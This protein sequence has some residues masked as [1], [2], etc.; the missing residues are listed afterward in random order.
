MK[1]II[2]IL[3]AALINFSGYSKPKKKEIFEHE[4][5][6]LVPL[7]LNTDHSDFGPAI[8]G[9]S[10]YFSS[11]SNNLNAKNKTSMQKKA[12]Y[13]L[14]SSNIDNQGN[15]IGKPDVIKDFVTTYHD[16]PVSW[17]DA[18]KE[19][20]ITQSNSQEPGLVYNPF[21][22]NY[23][24]LRIIIAK[25][26][27]GT[28]KNVESFPYNDPE[29]S[30][31]HPA[32]S[33]TGDTLIFS[34]NQP[35][36]YG[37]TDLYICTRKNG[38]WNKP[39]NL[40]NRINTAGKDEF[41]FFT[42]HGDL[43]YASSG[44]EGMG[45][46]DIY[47]T[48]LNDPKSE[49]LHFKSPINSEYDDFSLIFNKDAEYGYMTSNRPGKGG[50]DIYKFTFN[51]YRDNLLELLVVDSKTLKPIPGAEV[52]FNDKMDLKT[53]TEGE[54][55][56]QITDEMSLEI[57]VKAF[58]YSDELKTIQT[59]I[60]K[61][62]ELISDTI[63]M[64]MIV[65]ENIV[66]KN[67]YYDFDKWDLLPESM[68]ELDK[69]SSFMVE[70]PE[71]KVNLSAHT[72]SRGTKGYNQK[73]S[74]LRVHSVVD[75]LLSKG[76]DADRMVGTGYGETNPVNGCVDMVMCSPDQFR[77]NRR[78]EFFIPELGKSVSVEQVGK[79]DYTITPN[80]KISSQN[81]VHKKKANK[82]AVIIGSFKN[83]PNAENM[84]GQLKKTGYSPEIINDE[85]L[86][87]V[88]VT[89]KDIESAK[90]GLTKLKNNYP[91]AWMQ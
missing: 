63:L 67:I 30:V 14:Y 82:Y 8:I 9:E 23:Y 32:V 22:K 37:Q 3:I 5:V 69:L 74:D 57:N 73:L 45:G 51:R 7:P 89:F 84:L 64:D 13:D 29:Y 6:K 25:Q 36:G 68:E 40:G 41:P 76:I 81:P 19:L 1:K 59:G 66:L 46:L 16:G 53:G 17:C 79:G 4:T 77:M 50:D 48:R 60:L 15:I 49:I 58:G 21:R 2:L 12:F 38:Q 56:R 91:G 10:L 47:Y 72:D 28:W 39:V 65:K 35:G 33:V 44:R 24:N 62:G 61:S 83:L 54:I 34:S 52:A 88:E 86:F 43:I 18:T 26:D 20:F 80:K 85:N 75:Y 31:G 71:V 78:T 42:D 87:T 11:F 55:T 70:N 27:N 90:E